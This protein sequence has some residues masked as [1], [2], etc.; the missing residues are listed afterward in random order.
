MI[1]WSRKGW[2]FPGNKNPA[3]FLEFIK[4]NEQVH[5]I[6]MRIA[7]AQSFFLHICTV[8]WNNKRLTV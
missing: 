3:A 6:L 2:L 4:L 1:I 5:G 7:Y 8:I